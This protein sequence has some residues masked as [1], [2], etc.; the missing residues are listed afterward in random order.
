MA[1]CVVT[2]IS[3]AEPVNGTQVL[4]KCECFTISPTLNEQFP[5]HFTLDSTGNPEIQLRTAKAAYYAQFY[6]G[7]VLT[8]VI[9][10]GLG[11]VNV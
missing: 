3:G 4:L 6:P 8:R 1:V 11:L 7:E 5:F 9:L 10:P 2:G